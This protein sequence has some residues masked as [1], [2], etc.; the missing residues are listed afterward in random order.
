MNAFQVAPDYTRD[1]RDFL[2]PLSLVER[3]RRILAPQAAQAEAVSPLIFPANSIPVIDISG[4]GQTK[5]I[6]TAFPSLVAA[7]W[8]LV[9]MRASIGL[10]PDGLFDY[11]WRAA[12]DSGMYMMVYHFGYSTYTGESQ[13]SVFLKA[14]EPMLTKV[15]GHS[16]GVLDVEAPGLVTAW[17]KTILDF[18]SLVKTKLLTGDYSSVSKWLS[19]TNNMPVPGFA[20]NASWSNIINVPS[21]A[22]AAQTVLRQA[23]V[24]LKHAWIPKPP[25]VN[26]DVDVGYFMGN[27]QT[28]RKFLGYDDTP[29]PPPPSNL[30]TRVI[31]LE[32][33]VSTLESK[34]GTLENKVGTL[35]TENRAEHQKMESDIAN[36]RVDVNALQQGQP[37]P[38]PDPDPEDENTWTMT[39][40]PE[41]P[42]D[43]RTQA[44]CFEVWN[45]NRQELVEKRNDVQP[46][47]KPIMQPY[48]SS[49]GKHITYARN[50]PLVTYKAL[51]DTDG[52]T[53]DCYEVYKQFGDHRERLFVL[54]TEVMKPY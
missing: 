44:W 40:R 31:T 25:G 22:P 21:F 28:L 27:E 18:H 51:V 23:G 9:I 54:K 30:E 43:P 32:S 47:G 38:D 13:G 48:L 12:Y 46:I 41:K 17:R 11:F 19:C 49:N 24:Y 20:W 29:P 14:I 7:G 37:N 16:A 42:D 39:V 5:A 8:K 4:I 36:L 3:L 6:A 2:T 50:D 45:E 52:S 34:V 35:I 1:E 26:E 33:K 15:D 53:P 10:L